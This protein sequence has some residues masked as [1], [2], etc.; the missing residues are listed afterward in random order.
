MLI[1]KNSYVISFSQ[2][3]N[4][5]KSSHLVS[6]LEEESMFYCSVLGIQADADQVLPVIK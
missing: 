3:Y 6:F 1:Q 2:N 4:L 5:K